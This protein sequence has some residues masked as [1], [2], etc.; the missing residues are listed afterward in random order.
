MKRRIMLGTYVC[1]GTVH[2]AYYRK[3]QN[4]RRLI[5]KDFFDAF[6]SVDSL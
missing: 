2:D 6:A 3:A 5:Q 4:V 1:L